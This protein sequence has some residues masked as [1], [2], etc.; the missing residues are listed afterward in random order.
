MKIIKFKGEK[1]L[2]LINTVLWSITI[3]IYQKAKLRSL[4]FL[5]CKSVM[6]PFLEKILFICYS[7]FLSSWN[8]LKLWKTPKRKSD[9]FVKRQVSME[10]K[11][12]GDLKFFTS[13]VLRKIYYS[14][15][16][17]KCTFL[18][19]TLTFSQKKEKLNHEKHI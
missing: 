6:Y 1:N 2:F 5:T 3:K 7:Y 4:F 13:T 16:M 18:R 17:L 9:Q 15:T 11:K 14:E 19:Q 10:N 12:E 8:P